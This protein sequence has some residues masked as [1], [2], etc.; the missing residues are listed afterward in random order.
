MTRPNVASPLVPDV[1]AIPRKLPE[2]GPINLIGLSREAMRDGLLGPLVDP[3]QPDQ[4]KAAILAQIDQPR[5][6]PAGLDY[7]A[8]PQFCARMQAL[9]KGLT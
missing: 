3:L 7:F 6:I 4:L 2:G 8:F 5:G 9:V 1:H